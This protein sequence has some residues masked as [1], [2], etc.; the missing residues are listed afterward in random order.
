VLDTWWKVALFVVGAWLLLSFP[1]AVFLGKG[2]SVNDRAEAREVK[3]EL[4][5][6]FK[7][8]RRPRGPAREVQEAGVRSKPGAAGR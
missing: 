8:H 2:A 3:G 1:V 7:E 6:S 5:R 4:R